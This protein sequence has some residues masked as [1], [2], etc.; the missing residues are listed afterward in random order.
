[1]SDNRSSEHLESWYDMMRKTFKKGGLPEEQVNEVIQ[2]LR[3]ASEEHSAKEA[4][5]DAEIKSRILAEQEENQSCNNCRFWECNRT[6][7]YLWRASLNIEEDSSKCLRYP[8]EPDFDGFITYLET[9]SHDWCG[10]WKGTK[11]T[12]L[13]ISL[14]RRQ[15]KKKRSER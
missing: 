5:R 10:E 6:T 1:M 11:I 3:L 15:A 13:D 7:D 9:S 2:R 4:H 12:D 8:P 14:I